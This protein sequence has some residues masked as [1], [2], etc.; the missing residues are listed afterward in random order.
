MRARVT[1]RLQ[2]HDAPH[3]LR[4]VDGEPYRLRPAERV[5]DQRGPLEPERIEDRQHVRGE[6]RRVIAGQPAARLPESASRD[7]DGAITPR[8]PRRELV[9]GVRSAPESGE[10]HH[11]L[12]TTAPVE[13]VEPH[14][15]TDGRCPRCGD[16]S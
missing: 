10:E 9:E 2:K 13:I 14:A 6:G 12:A 4:V 7:R 3:A 5:P 1:V 8:Q 15:I 11:G 16:R